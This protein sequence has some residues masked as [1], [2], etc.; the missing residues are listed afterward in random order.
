MLGRLDVAAR[1]GRLHTWLGKK[2]KRRLVH[3]HVDWRKVIAEKNPS[4]N[5]FVYTA[6]ENVGTG[7]AIADGQLRGLG[8][9]IKDNICTA[10]MPT[11]CSSKMLMGMLF[12]MSQVLF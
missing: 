3:S 2:C 9:A 12:L 7:R 5:A 1:T 6:P 8:I 10:D 4:V 11:T